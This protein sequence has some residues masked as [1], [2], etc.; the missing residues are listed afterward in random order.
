MK[1]SPHQ[2]CAKLWI[3]HILSNEGALAYL[4][5]G[6]MVARYAAVDAAG[7]ISEADKANLPPADLLAKVQFLTADQQ[8]AADAAIQA[9]WGPMVADA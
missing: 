2:A 4:Q 7:V 5:G 6:A 8:S 3:E 1:D 9:N